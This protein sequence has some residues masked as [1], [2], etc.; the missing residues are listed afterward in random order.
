MRA[1]DNMMYKTEDEAIIYNGQLQEVK[2]LIEDLQE[3]GLNV[4][5]AKQEI[6]NI[7]KMVSGKVE[8]NYNTY[9]DTTSLL[10]TALLYDYNSAIKR[11]D[12]LKTILIAEWKDYYI[13]VNKYNEIKNSINNVEEMDFDQ[14][15]ESLI[16]ILGLMR[17]ST[18]INFE[19]EKDIVERLYE[20]I[21]T[22]M[23]LEIIYNKDSR[24]LDTIKNNETDSIYI[25]NILKKE[26]KKIKND[27]VDKM[28]SSLQSNGMD[29]RNL[30]D[31]KLIMLV[32]AVNEPEIIK[33]LM[34]EY[35]DNIKRLEET[36]EN[37]NNLEDSLNNN[38]YYLNDR[39]EKDKSFKKRYKIKLIKSTINALLLS[40]ILSGGILTLK[41]HGF[42][43]TYK[44][45]ETTYDSITDETTTSNKYTKGKDN[46]I[47]LVEET[48]WREPEFFQE[49]E[50]KKEKYIYEVPEEVFESCKEPKDLLNKDYYNQIEPKDYVKES[51]KE[52]PED[53]SIREN[54]VLITSQKKD[55]N[56]SK[57]VVN[58]FNTVIIT[59]TTLAILILLEQI[60]KY[61]IDKDKFKNI[62]DY[63]NLNLE[64]IENSKKRIKKLTNDININN[65]KIDEI[66][67]TLEEELEVLETISKA[68]NDVA[69]QLKKIKEKN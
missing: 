25:A 69:K 32:S 53:Y 4:D 8:H 15:V 48:P 27:E 23:K 42:D 18:T 14:I 28:V 19:I 67:K 62:K 68:D 10:N 61:F 66:Q 9:D 33:E 1:S 13:I 43:D 45:E 63:K 29:S 46:K 37:N 24:L 16:D 60:F 38:N 65:E 34:D 40:L 44:T 54:R 64:E 59:L 3:I 20:L 6:N 51:S 36:K 30:L 31:K 35:K 47:V 41:N 12:I 7:E 56:V 50:Y 17:A 2:S 26:I 58:T 21:Y 52:K 57:K 39:I 22:V 5:S 55:L 49:K 11:L